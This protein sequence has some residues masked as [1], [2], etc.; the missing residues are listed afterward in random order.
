MNAQVR[1][2]GVDMAAVL[3]GSVTRGA[4]FGAVL[5]KPLGIILV[6]LVLVKLG[7]AKFPRGM[8]VKQAI[9]M[10]L[11]GGVGFTMSIL[12]SGLAFADAQEQLE[13]K[14]AI[15]AASVTSALLGLAF[16]HIADAVTKGRK[17]EPD[18]A[19]ERAS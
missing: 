8:D 6:T 18:R 9:T 4:Y 19:S 3:A 13:A 15:L 5:G 7:F 14:C 16:I 17:K 2:V 10:G 12:I 11:M 1:L